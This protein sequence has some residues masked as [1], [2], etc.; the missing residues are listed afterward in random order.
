[1]LRF[2][3]SLCGVMILVTSNTVMVR[4]QAFLLLVLVE[5]LGASC[6][7]NRMAVGAAGGLFQTASAEME[8]ESDWDMAAKALPA[9]LKTVAG[10]HSIDPTNKDL[11]QAL[12]KGYTA[13]AFGINETLY[14]DER[15]ADVTGGP[16]RAETI[17]N[18]SKALAYG[19]QFLAT[20]DLTA[21][22]LFKA[23]AEHQ[24][25]ALLG[26]HFSAS[27]SAGVATLLFTV[28]AWA[29]LINL[30]KSNATLL[31]QLS[32]V[33]QLADFGCSLAPDFQYGFCEMFAA[34]YEA[35]RPKALGGDPA[36]AQSIFLAAIKKYPRSLMVREAYIERYLVPLGLKDEYLKEK[37]SVLPLLKEQQEQA[38]FI[39][40]EAS[41]QDPLQ[42]KTAFLSAV[43]AKRLSII[44]RHESSL[45]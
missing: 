40:G 29:N 32:I 28:Q 4:F 25:D 35:S 23:N 10:L 42:V 15:F 8:S 37:T 31:S 13:Y 3:K 34:S 43:A 19:F 21:D 12:V 24:L 44:Q 27:D 41:S 6:S 16:L 33:K 26:A 38:S 14:L 2:Q 17:R 39:P 1:M 20:Y 18:Y 11:L 7:L 45:F 22:A 9:N 30:Q 36:K 5:A